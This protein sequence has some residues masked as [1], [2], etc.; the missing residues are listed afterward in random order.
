MKQYLSNTQTLIT[1]AI[2]SLLLFVPF[3]GAVHLFDWDEINFAEAAREMIVTG[4]YSMVQI[5]YQPFWEKP[6]L[7]FWLQIIAMKI[8]GINEFA[9]R[10]PNAI[11]GLTTLIV[12]FNIGKKLISYQFGV[13]WS[14]IYASSFLPHFYFKSGIIDPWFNLF[15]FL[16]IYYLVKTYIY[17]NENKLKN[18]LISGAFIGL[19]VMTKGPV[20]LL[21]FLLVYSVFVL[22][23]KF[24]KM[25]SI[26][27]MLLFLVALIVTGTSWFIVEYLRGRGD[28]IYDFIIYQIRLLQTKD[29][30]H[31][32]PFIYHFIVLLVGCFPASIFLLKSF[33]K[34]AK[35]CERVKSFNKWMKILFWV[36]LILFSLVKTKIVH[37]SSLT[38][39][40]LTYL[41]AYVFYLL[42]EKKQMPIWLK[43]MF[44]FIGSILGLAITG[45]PFID[46]YKTEIINSNLIKDP[47]AVANLQAN[48]YWSGF[49]FLIGVFFI[50]GIIS[51]IIL[52]KK[53]FNFGMYALLIVSLITINLTSLIYAPKVEQYSQGAAIEFYQS[54]QNEDC[55][56][57]TIGFKS[58][59]H[60]YYSNKKPQENLNSLNQSWLLSG[61]I[62]K[63]SYFVAKIIHEE[64][65][66]KNHPLLKLINRK[67]GFLFY[68]RLP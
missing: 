4:D 50:L 68:E 11:A 2:I 31:G 64:D 30:G 12:L 28:V 18:I 45:L 13:I 35:D 5:N 63:P 60:L 9:A 8:F 14:L 37:Y 48:V 23:N 16:G 57:T 40:P 62:D 43:T 19:G 6:P 27:L 42:L 29:A 66:A 22:M 38:Y 20:A 51:A 34:E 54:K 58:Y 55:Y 10:F 36:V 1:I 52:L 56:I 44:I 47:F 49:E 15:I 24:K 41:G 25:V 39:F 32:G 46:K 21:I 17:E 59:A 53:R 33:K 7:F 26:K 65:I 3:L 61:E 67:N